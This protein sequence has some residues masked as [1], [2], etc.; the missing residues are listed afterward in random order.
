MK[1]T[2]DLVLGWIRKADSDLENVS[3]CLASGK[4]LDTACF[5][6][7]QAAEKLLKAYLIAYG[8]PAPLIHNIEKL[9]ELCEQ[10]NHAFLSVKPLGAILTPYAVQLRYDEDFWPSEQ[11]TAAALQ[12]AQA[13][14]AFVIPLLPKNMQ[15]PV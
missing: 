7:Q 9:V 4:S 6:T 15:P 2:D 1:T 8:L 14:R 5:H 11:E 12:S 10:H 3:L 13:L